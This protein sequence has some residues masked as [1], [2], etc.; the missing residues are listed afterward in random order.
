MMTNN[1]TPRNF[2]LLSL[3]Y[4]TNLIALWEIILPLNSLVDAI[5]VAENNTKCGRFP[6]Y[7]STV[8]S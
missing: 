8:K 1:V 5:T 2:I 6:Q 7:I 4:Y 3:I